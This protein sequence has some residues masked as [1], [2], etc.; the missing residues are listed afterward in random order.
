MHL[1]RADDSYFARCQIR[2]EDGGFWT[3]HAMGVEPPNDQTPTALNLKA[4][5]FVS[6]GA[7]RVRCPFC[8]GAQFANPETQTRFMCCDCA[9]G[10]ADHAWIGVEW[11]DDLEEIESALLLRPSPDNMNWLPHESAEHLHAENVDHGLV[12]L[13]EL[14]KDRQ[15][16]V[17]LLV[18]AAHE[19]NPVHAVAPGTFVH[20]QSEWH[21]R[22][23]AKLLKTMGRNVSESQMQRALMVTFGKDR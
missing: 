16:L 5:A 23:H 18:D 1:R 11:P 21:A 2:A 22:T 19:I 7:W 9:N 6:S 10:G 3:L 4:E 14:P 17:G 20:P 13:K 12:T 8:N 15:K